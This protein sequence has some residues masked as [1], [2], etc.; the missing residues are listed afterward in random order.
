MSGTP[1][2]DESAPAT[3]ES[4]GAVPST[5]PMTISPVDLGPAARRMADLVATLPA[6]AL[7]RPTPCEDYTVGDLLDHVAGAAAAF[8][9]AA[10]KDPLPAAGP[11]D[12]ANLAPDWQARL[13]GDVMALARAW[14]DPGAW[15][16]TTAAGGVELPGAVAGIVAL[17][18]LLLHGWDLARATGRAYDY[19]GPGLDIVFDQVTY[20]RS[21][22]L[23]GI[24][25]PEVPIPDDAPL[26]RR[27][28]GV[29]GRDPDWQP[30]EGGEQ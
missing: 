9:A 10:V 25:G 3:D 19:D 28:L 15:T 21:L 1:S 4:G 23:E 24:F 7:G 16:G 14:D 5:P 27:V 18:E 29:A 13:P 6:D 17:D 12:A 8:R 11:G 2:P 22:G 20:F 30:P 26:F